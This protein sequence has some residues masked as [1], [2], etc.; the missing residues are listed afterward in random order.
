MVIDNKLGLVL[1]DKAI[2]KK[3]NGVIGEVIKQLF[4]ALFT[5]KP[6]SLSVKIFE[7]KSTLERILKYWSFAPQFLSKGNESS[8]PIERMKWA[9]S[10]CVSGLYVSAKQLKPFNPILGETYQG[11]FD[12][13]SKVYAEHTGHYPSAARYLIDDKNFKFSG[14]IEFV[15]DTEGL[16]SKI[17]IKQQGTLKVEYNKYKDSPIVY[18]LP[19]IKLL[20]AKSEENRS[21]IWTGCAVFA[22][23]KNNLKGVVKFDES[24]KIIH[25]FE[26][27]IYSHKFPANY[28]FDSI[29]E[30][31]LGEKKCSDKILTSCKGSWLE[32]IKFENKVY[33]DINQNEPSFL[34]PIANCLPSDGR[35]RED[36]TWLHRSFNATNEADRIKFQDYAQEWKLNLEAMQRNER[37]IRKKSQK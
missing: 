25:S 31:K 5:G 32:N 30:M 24:N 20:N 22:D 11:V 37:D 36:L 33:W 18:N 12:E 7:P 16:G 8:D 29:S 1:V 27:S 23:V 35:Y 34:N 3:F 10:L 19:H 28:K 14:Y 13:G 21:S 17:V 4:K 2:C 15:T 6:V 9:I 26:G